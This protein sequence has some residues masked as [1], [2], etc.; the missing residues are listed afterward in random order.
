MSDQPSP[1]PETPANPPPA[2]APA[3]KE[4]DPAELA[5]RSLA[6]APAKIPAVASETARVDPAASPARVNSGAAGLH[7]AAGDL[8][9]HGRPFDPERHNGSKHPRTGHWMPKKKGRR[10]VTA[11]PAVD[12]VPGWSEAERA[13]FAGRSAQVEPLADEAAGVPETAAPPAAEPS[14]AAE[15]AT[16]ALYLGTGL[17]TG[18]PA[19]ARLKGADH[20][21]LK[22]TLA[23]YFRA[24]GW[25]ITG[26]LAVALAVV[27]YFLKVGNQPKTGETL[28]ERWQAWRAA[29]ARPVADEGAEIPAEPARPRMD[30]PP[31]NV[32]H[33]PFSHLRR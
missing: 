4:I 16:N 32:M 19:E 14:D 26:G 7:P 29:R 12:S 28:R 22:N 23:A 20:E 5:A 3:V 11:G 18:H 9:A 13:T 8:D 21:S 33:D 30:V 1:V 31:A 2:V 10:S 6:T 17:A 27:A 15:V 25:H 24:R